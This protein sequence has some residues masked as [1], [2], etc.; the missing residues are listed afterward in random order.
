MSLTNVAIAFV[1]RLSLLG[2]WGNLLKFTQNCCLD[3][4]TTQVLTIWPLSCL[5]VVV[6]DGIV[7]VQWVPCGE[8][9]MVLP[10]RF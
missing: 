8:W 6:N 10:P 2:T 4:D 7:R 3:N 9:D 1:S 5:D